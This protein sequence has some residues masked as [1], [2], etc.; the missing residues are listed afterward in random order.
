MGESK[1]CRVDGWNT[2]QLPRE[3][4]EGGKM[5]VGDLVVRNP[6]QWGGGLDDIGIIVE[7]C[8]HV[9]ETVLVQWIEVGLRRYYNIYD[10]EL[11]HESRRL[12]KS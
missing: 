7:N 9:E 5:Q 3:K 6:T 2:M 10:L 1:G 11:Y 12:G 8:P 4:L